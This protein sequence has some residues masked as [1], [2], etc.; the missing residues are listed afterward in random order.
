MTLPSSS[1]PLIAKPTSPSAENVILVT[2]AVNGRCD[3]TGARAS[4]TSDTAAELAARG[5]RA[6]LVLLQGR[7]GRA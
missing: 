3:H 6:L 7:G 5:E 1:H 2:A 4:S